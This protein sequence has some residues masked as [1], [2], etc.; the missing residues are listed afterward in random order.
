MGEEQGQ[1]TLHW[2]CAI[3]LLHDFFFNPVCTSHLHFVLQLLFFP[4]KVGRVS[5]PYERLFPDSFFLTCMICS[6][7]EDSSLVTH[8]TRSPEESPV[9]CAVTFTKEHGE[10]DIGKACFCV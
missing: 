8:S 3:P 9:Y 7:E 1:E 10:V 4:V 6:F 2:S 5:C